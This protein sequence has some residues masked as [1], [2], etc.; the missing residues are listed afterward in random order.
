MLA[1]I[2]YNIKLIANAIKSFVAV[3][4][5]PF[6]FQR[7]VVANGEPYEVFVNV[8]YNIARDS[9]GQFVVIGQAYAIV[10]I[11]DGIGHTS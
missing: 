10:N 1:G 3:K 6:V 5:F 8:P 2:G 7:C 11:N 4:Y 9:G